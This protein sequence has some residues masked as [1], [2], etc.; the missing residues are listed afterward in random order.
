MGNLEDVNGELIFQ[1]HLYVAH[2]DQTNN[3]S[4]NAC[5]PMEAKTKKTRIKLAKRCAGITFIVI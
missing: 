5:L 1:V 3:P 2:P 4:I